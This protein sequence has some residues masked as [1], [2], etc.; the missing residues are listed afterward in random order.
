MLHQF[1]SVHFN[2]SMHLRIF[3]QALTTCICISLLAYLSMRIIFFDIPFNLIDELMTISKVLMTGSSFATGICIILLLVD[4][5]HYTI[6]KTR[7]LQP[8]FNVKS[9]AIAT[10]LLIIVVSAAKA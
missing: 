1:F 10:L 4:A 7:S 9:T 6:H 5:I 8:G 3:K 2:A